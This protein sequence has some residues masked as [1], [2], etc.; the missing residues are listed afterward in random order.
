[1]LHSYR[2]SRAESNYLLKI[3]ANIKAK[4]NKK[5]DTAVSK[6]IKNKQKQID[7]NKKI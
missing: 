3:L 1:M 2:F 6:R 5:L 4:R 7:W